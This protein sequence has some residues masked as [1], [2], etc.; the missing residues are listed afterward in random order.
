MT[1]SNLLPYFEA[2]FAAVV[3][4]A[5]FIATKVALKDVSPITI[6]WLRFG[7]GLLVL[8][9]AVAL[10]KEFSLPKKNEWGY[11]ALLGFL[12]ITFHQWLQSNGLQTSEAGTTAWIVATTPV[13][14]AILGWLILKEGLSLV[15]IFGIALAFF[16][17]LLVVSDGNLASISIGKFGA[18]GDI[19]ILVSAVNWAVVSVL[20]RRGLKTTSASLFV[21]YMMLFGWLFASALFVGNGLI[22]EVPEL[23]F[24]GWL[25]ITFLGIFCSGLAYIAWYDALQAL[26]TASTGV[27]LYIEPL[28]AMVVA[29]FIL[30]E[31]I[32]I[33]SLVGGGVILFGVWLVNR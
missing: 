14:M 28:I 19:L 15:K 2:T 4:G 9:A 13:F 3:W 21:F 7:M 25:G 22:V 1:K 24:N 27:F 11:F 5:S 33:A 18:P 8:G 16:G 10:R 32:T 29:F 12:G 30:N 31:A 23:T 20:S 26:T 17:V 6:V